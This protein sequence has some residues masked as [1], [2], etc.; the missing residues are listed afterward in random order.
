LEKARK[1]GSTWGVDNVICYML[2]GFAIYMISVFT[3]FFV[4]KK[5]NADGELAI[6]PDTSGI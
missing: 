2:L 3:Y 4:I 1:A 6:D 5:K